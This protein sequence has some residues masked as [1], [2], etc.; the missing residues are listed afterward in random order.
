M[1]LTA[2]HTRPRRT[3]MPNVPRYK[4]RFR[5]PAALRAAQAMEAPMSQLRVVNQKRQFLG[6]RLPPAA[7]DSSAAVRV[8]ETQL[9][10]YEEN[11]GGEIVEDF[12]YSMEAEIFD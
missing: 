2:Q 10:S 3:E 11:F 6:V 9:R 5:D 1:S 12:Q 4:I 7:R 8:F